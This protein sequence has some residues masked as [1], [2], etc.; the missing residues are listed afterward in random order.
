MPFILICRD[1]T[2]PDCINRR[3]ANR[4]AHLAMVAEAVKNGKQIF[5]IAIT[6]DAGKMIGSV[7]IMT[8]ETREEIDAWLK[9]EPYVTGN[10]WDDIEVLNGVVP[11]T[12]A[13]FFKK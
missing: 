1:A 2:D 11:Q 8:M 3:L 10:V 7:M 6:D 9:V 5:G 4:D 12:F 13:H